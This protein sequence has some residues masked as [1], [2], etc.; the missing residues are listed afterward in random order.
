MVISNWEVRNEF[1]DHAPLKNGSRFHYIM[2][3][4]ENSLYLCI[5]RTHFSR[6]H[7]AQ[8]IVLICDKSLGH[9][10]YKIGI[11]DIKVI[12]S[13]K[14]SSKPKIR[15]DDW[16]MKDGWRERFQRTL[17]IFNRLCPIPRAIKH[18]IAETFALKEFAM[19]PL[20]DPIL[21]TYLKNN[22]RSI[23]AFQ[24]CMVRFDV[25]IEIRYLILSHLFHPP[26][27]PFQIR[28]HI[29][30]VKRELDKELPTCTIL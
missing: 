30:W 9:N 27:P 14:A 5:Q 16:L 2:Q 10:F 28:H 29:C 20:Y 22:F 13:A 21:F 15:F 17:Q 24:L 1:T 12:T 4:A 3:N 11:K 26:L 7:W 23:R 6:Y 19:E 8:V 18:D 25:L